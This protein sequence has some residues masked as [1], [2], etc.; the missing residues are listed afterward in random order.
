[1]ESLIE[2]SDQ[3]LSH[4]QASA[5]SLFR[6]SLC[7]FKTLS[8][9]SQLKSFHRSYR[10]F[11]PL[12]FP[13]RL[14]CVQYWKECELIYCNLYLMAYKSLD[15]S[16]VVRKE[17]E[18]EITLKTSGVPIDPASA[19]NIIE[20]GNDVRIRLFN[21]NE[22]LQKYEKSFLLNVRNIKEKIIGI[23]N[24]Y[25]EE[26]EKLSI[27]ISRIKI[28]I[29]EPDKM[30]PEQ[31]AMKNSI[32]LLLTEIGQSFTL[33]EESIGIFLS[34]LDSYDKLWEKLEREK[35]QQRKNCST[36]L[37]NLMATFTEVSLLRDKLVKSYK[38]SEFQKKN[39]TIESL[40]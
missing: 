14:E 31:R 24:Y 12:D 17:G 8:L 13:E 16:R 7:G 20:T 32:S 11:F 27:F 23:E 33:H 6:D 1:M 4:I 10:E 15:R 29:N 3:L 38:L 30:L 37:D 35:S 9:I 22:A 26:C 39:E 40:F 18:E 34:Q 25:E 5:D 2:E 36:Y 28:I 19:F 21:D